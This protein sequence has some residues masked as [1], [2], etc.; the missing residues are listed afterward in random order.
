MPDDEPNWAKLSGDIQDGARA[1]NEARPLPRA[2]AMRWQVEENDA[3]PP[4]AEEIRKRAHEGSFAGP[5]M[6]E[7]H[8]GRRLAAARLQHI[9]HDLAGARLHSSRLGR[10]QMEAGP[11]RESLV[12][13]RAVAR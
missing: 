9:G 2:Q 3:H 4:S 5:A 1:V 7:E 11:L 10:A 12:I 8:A 6:D 13:R